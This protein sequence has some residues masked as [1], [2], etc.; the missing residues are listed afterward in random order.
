[1]QDTTL[2]RLLELTRGL[3]ARVDVITQTLGESNYQYYGSNYT[4]DVIDIRASRPIVQNMTD[5][6]FTFGEYRDIGLP[7]FWYK[8]LT[9]AAKGD[10]VSAKAWMNPDVG[11]IL[12]K[13]RLQVIIQNKDGT[14]G[15]ANTPVTLMMGVCETIPVVFK[16][17]KAP[18]R[19]SPENITFTE[20]QAGMHIN[21]HKEARELFVR[22]YCIGSI[23]A[24]QSSSGRW[25]FV[26]IQAVMPVTDEQYTG[27]DTWYRVASRKL[28]ELHAWGY[29]HGDAHRGNIMQ[30]AVE[31]ELSKYA[32][33]GK[34]LGNKIYFIDFDRV[35]N[36]SFHPD[37]DK[38]SITAK[39]LCMMSDY[40]TM[41]YIHNN[42]IPFFNLH[43][44]E[45]V[46][47]RWDKMTSNQIMYDALIPPFSPFFLSQPNRMEHFHTFALQ[48]KTGFCDWVYKNAKTIPKTIQ[49]TMASKSAMAEL[50]RKLEQMFREASTGRPAAAVPAA[51]DRP[52]AGPTTPDK[53]D[54]APGVGPG[55]GSGQ[56]PV[57]FRRGDYRKY[58]GSSG[59]AQ[60]KP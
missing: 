8:D 36:I 40:Y 1:M 14:N 37:D 19:F 30:S 49:T 29:I 43:G 18:S 35:E 58:T 7:N 59:R 10:R 12:T 51:R 50:N 48:D 26:G 27:D 56:R 3:H 38:Y 31:P 21:E 46:E 55:A 11:L 25:D 2:S 9:A 28:G 44:I 4:P 53:Q 42:N 23:P 47:A 20:A 24:A 39:V 17:R 52:P 33:P 45:T 5:V 54:S 41:L 32:S 13:V 57:E 16:F 15:I 6:Y 34:R 22:I 60:A